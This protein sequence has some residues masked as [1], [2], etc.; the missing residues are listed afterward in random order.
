MHGRLKVR[1]TEEQAER[2]RLEREKKLKAYKY[3]MSECLLRIKNKQFDETG[4]K[5]SE[6][7]LAS[8]PDIQTLWNLRKKNVEFFEQSACEEDTIKILTEICLKKN[9]KSYPTWYHRQWCLLRSNSRKLGEKNENLNWK[10]ELNLCSKFLN[11]DER[12]FHCWRHRFFVVAHGNLEK[13]NELE[14]TSD[15]IS[16]N[17]SNYSSWHYRNK[18]IEELY[19]Q[20]QIDNE[21]FKNELNLIENAVYTDPNDQSAWIYQK[22]LLLEHQKSIIKEL[23]LDC[24]NREISIHFTKEIDLNKNFKFDENG[25]RLEEKIWK[26]GSNDDQSEL[27]K[28]FENLTRS[29]HSKSSGFPIE[30]LLDLNDEKNLYEFKSKFKMRDLTLDSEILSNHFGNMMELNQFEN[31]NSKWCML[32]LVELMG[33]MDFDKYKE[34][35]FSY[36]DKLADQVDPYRKNYYLDIKC[37]LKENNS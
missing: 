27:N 28:L 37:K 18:L 11:Q 23:V 36:L 1:T 3:A 9:P 15:K 8:N 22:W 26:T 10:N 13:K 25:W 35:I 19:Y 5:L 24:K 34:N 33:I 7:V 32:K 20:N 2:K 21:I 14:F 30:L 16:S 6:Q 12:N 31:E 4:Q 17:F 29:R